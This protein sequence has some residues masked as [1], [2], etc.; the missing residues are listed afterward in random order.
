MFHPL[1]WHPNITSFKILS[2]HF[3]F[4]KSL[5]FSFHYDLLWF[6]ITYFFQFRLH[7]FYLF[8][9]LHS[10]SAFFFLGGIP[11]LNMW[12]ITLVCPLLGV[13]VTKTRWVSH[14]IHELWFFCTL[15]PYLEES[16][17]QTRMSELSPSLCT[18]Y[19]PSTWKIESKIENKRDDYCGKPHHIYIRIYRLLFMFRRLFHINANRWQVN[20]S[21]NI[22]RIV[23]FIHP[24]MNTLK[25]PSSVRMPKVN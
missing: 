3:F 6:M 5:F 17:I 21:S 24:S 16:N 13:S 4:T 11:T 8:F 1:L 7:I 14:L 15:L 22:Q 18:H 12:H 10:S 20:G 19:L 23:Q 25:E 9:I 2:Q